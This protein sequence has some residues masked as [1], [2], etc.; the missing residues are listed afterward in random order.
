WALVAAGV[1]LWRWAGSW[2]ERRVCGAIWRRENNRPREF[3]S[4]LCRHVDR[5]QSNNDNNNR[6]GTVVFATGNS[7]CF[8]LCCFFRAPDV[9]VPSWGPSQSADNG[10]MDAILV[11]ADLHLAGF[12]G[13][14]E[15][16]CKK[17]V[18]LYQKYANLCIKD[19][20]LAH[21]RL[22]FEQGQYQEAFV[23]YLIAAE[24]GNK[25]GQASLA[26]LLDRS[27]AA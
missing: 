18:G 14:L 6:Q 3:R 10:G 21:G 5:G 25:E 27:M 1:S 12:K 9:F 15:K 20:A 19:G 17:A 4:L 22:T 23:H 7:R 8:F 2:R 13:A 26:W 11:L 16:S 24:Q